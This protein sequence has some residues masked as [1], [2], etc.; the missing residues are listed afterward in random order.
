MSRKKSH[1]PPGIRQRTPTTWQIR[2]YAPDVNGV[3]ERQYETVVG[4]L[5]EAKAKR[6]Q[7]LAE[8]QKGAHVSQIPTTV[9]EHLDMWL[10]SQALVTA[11]YTISR[12]RTIA[13]LQ[14]YPYI[15]GVKLTKLTGP[16]L[17]KLYVHLQR[18]GSAKNGPLSSTTVAQAHHILHAAL[19]AAVRG[20]A[21]K[22][23]PADDVGEA[24]E[25]TQGQCRGP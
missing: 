3:P 23:N 21:L 14:I 18:E 8:V 2:Y 19:R 24:S 15:G 9:R 11:S 20:K 25:A 10:D 4:T 6:I 7:R 1:L 5:T 16:Q 22:S 12:Y 13:R 17:E